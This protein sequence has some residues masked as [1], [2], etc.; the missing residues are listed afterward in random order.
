MQT[1]HASLQGFFHLIIATLLLVFGA[2]LAFADEGEIVDASTETMDYYIQEFVVSAYYSPLPGQVRYAKGSYEAD[3][4]LNGRGTNGADGTEVFM[5]MLAAPKSYAFGTKIYLPGLGVGSVHD[6]GGAIVE[7][8]NYHRIDVWMGH[9]DEGLTR[10]MNWGMRK[11][12]G[13][14]YY[15]KS[16]TGSLDYR[17]VSGEMP[18][19]V[20]ATK[21][22]QQ[23]TQDF[24]KNLEEG[25]IDAEVITLKK[26]LVNL[27]YFS[28]EV[29]NNYFDTALTKAVIRFQI[30]AGLISSEKDS[31]A[32]YVGAK[33][34]TALNK[35]V[36]TQA[37]NT[38]TSNKTEQISLT[39]QAGLGKDATGEE[40]KALQMALKGLGYYNGAIDG[41]YSDDVISAVFAFQ[42]DQSVIQNAGDAGAGY[43]G[44]KTQKALAKALEKQ[45]EKIKNLPAPKFSVLEGTPVDTFHASATLTNSIDELGAK[46]SI[47]ESAF[48]NEGNDNIAQLQNMLAQQG[49]L[50]VKQ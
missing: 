1:K 28:G 39:I 30:D 50:P 2:S 25:S 27:G 20:K 49:F 35:G 23:A 3:V 21:A 8:G 32:G 34:R 42:K 29:R 43:F 5:G 47:V 13:K 26:T 31:G 41:V 11:V 36:L 38:A 4:Y 6:R 16:T 12:T 14:V 48:S 37:T 33:T 44:E 7:K 9:G 46:S 40:V 18:S 22:V 10:A 17:V 45:Q 19:W 15:N 24:S